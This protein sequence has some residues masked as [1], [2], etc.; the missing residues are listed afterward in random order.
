MVYRR[1]PYIRTLVLLSPALEAVARLLLPPRPVVEEEPTREPPSTET[2]VYE[3]WHEAVN[4]YQKP[5][6]KGPSNS[7][8]PFRHF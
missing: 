1:Y 2:T 8:P 6:P 3:W 7:F 4:D 5:L